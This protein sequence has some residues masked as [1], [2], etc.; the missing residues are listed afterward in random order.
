LIVRKIIR[1]I[2]AGLVTSTLDN[3]L[4]NFILTLI[5]FLL[6]LAL[7]MY[8][9]NYLGV[10]LTGVL[11][12]VT[13][14][15]LAV[16]LALQNIIAGV[17][18]GI[19]LATTHPFKV[20]DYVEIGGMGGTVQ[21]INLMHTVLNTPDGKH[22]YLPNS[23]VFSSNIVNFSANTMRR[24]DIPIAVDYASD[25][26]KVRSIILGT[27]TSHPLVLKDPAPQD[28]FNVTDSSSVTHVLRLWVLN[29]N[30]WTVNW[31]L[32]EQ[33]HEALKAAGI[34]IPFPQVTVSYRKGEDR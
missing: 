24:M 34:S 4:V 1:I 8:C 16:G 10:S 12:T 5:R 7:V 25:Q 27:A 19:M 28:R 13:A 6:Y 21:E 9:L 32:T 23:N 14:L 11:T 22:V 3:A 31:D 18:N 2:K 30:Y 17:A 15:T 20:N 26:E 33:T 29:S